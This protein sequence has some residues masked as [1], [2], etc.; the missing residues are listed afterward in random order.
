MKSSVRVAIV[1]LSLL[2]VLGCSYTQTHSYQIPL[3]ENPSLTRSAEFSEDSIKG[4]TYKLADELML[5]LQEGGRYGALA[6]VPFVDAQTLKKG[7]WMQ[8]SLAGLSHQLESSFI[9]EMHYRGFRVLDYKV[10]GNI[11]LKPESESIWSRDVSQLDTTP[12]VELLLSGTLTEHEKGAIVNVRLI[13][14]ESKTLLAA[15]NGFIPNTV[16]RSQR[17]VYAG[18]DG[19]FQG[20]EPART[21]EVK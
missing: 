14:A 7:T 13:H 5:S 8:S 19:I 2:S 15:A 6:V 3:N 11:Q 10:T 9:Y 1:S 4:Y 18:K 16:F 21:R 17:Q 20:P 12:D